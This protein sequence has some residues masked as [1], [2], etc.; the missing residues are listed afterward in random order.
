M[1]RR[2]INHDKPREKRTLIPA[3]DPEELA[4]E[5]EREAN[6]TTISP[7]FD[8]SSYARIVE[9]HVSLAGGPR[10]TPRSMA[11][12]ASIAATAASVAE[13]VAADER[14]AAPTAP[15]PPAPQVGVAEP[16]VDVEDVET[17][18]REMYGCYLAS[19]FPEALVL[20][21]RVLSHEPEHALA[22]L[23]AERCRERLQPSARTLSPS[24]VLRLKFAEL[25][26]H[27]RHIDPTSSF[28]LGHIDGVSDAATVAALTGLPGAEA[29][30]R[31]HALVDLGVLEVVSA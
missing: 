7:P 8:P 31:L 23:V 3:F 19:D 5:I 4:K 15:T 18:G 22:Q 24:S 6:R 20:A 14:R 27:A 1:R 2:R 26:R 28:V 10:D 12:A 30:N 17:V 16:T 25:E 9:E 11:A 29:L 13:R 21:E